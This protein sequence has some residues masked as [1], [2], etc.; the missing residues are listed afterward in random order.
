[1]GS[2]AYYFEREQKWTNNLKVRQ[3]QEKS[4]SL[5][6]DTGLLFSSENNWIIWII[7]FLKL[8]SRKYR[9]TIQLA[10]GFQLGNS[11]IGELIALANIMSMQL[12]F[13][14]VKLANF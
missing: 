3:T 2:D 4:L 14:S 6:S 9:S 5:S 10:P 8:I 7:L 1:M 11:V 12:G 13:L